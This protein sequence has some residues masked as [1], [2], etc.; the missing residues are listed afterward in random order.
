MELMQSMYDTQKNNPHYKAFVS[1]LPHPPIGV[2]DDH[3][4]GLNDAGK[5]WEHRDEAKQLFMD[6][7]EI[8]STHVMASRGGTFQAEVIHVGD[9]QVKFYLLD[10]RYFRDGL[11]DAEDSNLRYQP[12]TTQDSTLLGE[13]Q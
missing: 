8:D 11:L 6:F 4:Y 5:E 1:S 2:W 3:D 9:R 7:F 10:T 12:H 13:E